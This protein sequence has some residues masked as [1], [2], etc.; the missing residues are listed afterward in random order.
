MA[1]GQNEKAEQALC[2]LRGWATPETVKHEFLELVRYNETSGC[3]GTKTDAAGDPGV[4]A[5]L[6][7]F[8][9]PSVYRPLRLMMVFFF[10]AY[11]GSI[12]HTR[13][14]VTKMMDE[15]DIVDNQNESLARARTGR[16]QNRGEPVR[17]VVENPVVFVRRSCCPR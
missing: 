14:F 13:P 16:W 11:V 4:F 3:R 7:R 6:A 15:V 8:R 17:P 12:F 9:D 10:V 2:W 5:K 1:R